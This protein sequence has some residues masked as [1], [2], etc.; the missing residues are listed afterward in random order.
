MLSGPASA[1]PW[2]ALAATS[3]LTWWQGLLVL[4]GSVAARVIIRHQAER[5]R[6]L[7]LQMLI[8]ESPP[9]TVVTQE[10]GPGG[11]AL[12]VWIGTR[13][14]AQQGGQSDGAAAHPEADSIGGREV[15]PGRVLKVVPTRPTARSG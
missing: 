12:T 2:S 7:T 6:R 13:D 3:Y 10:K 1:E 14:A 9:G 15:V 4:L 8:T 5:S 11:P